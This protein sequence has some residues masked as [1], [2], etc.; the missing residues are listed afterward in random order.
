MDEPQ[1]TG[2]PEPYRPK[3][4]KKEPW[5]LR[6]GVAAGLLWAAVYVADTKPDLWWAA[7]GFGAFAIVCAWE[8]A[9]WLGGLLLVV[10]FFNGLSSLPTSTAIIIGALII[11]A[12]LDRD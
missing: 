11:A 2:S 9:L 5:W 10:W 1:P 6:Y 4:Q 3:P 8:L 7:L 12:A